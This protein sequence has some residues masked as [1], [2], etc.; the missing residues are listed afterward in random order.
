LVLR[1]AVR[2]QDGEA[3]VS[4][5]E[6]SRAKVADDPTLA[7]RMVD[8]LVKTH[9]YRIEAPHPFR[10]D[11]PDDKRSLALWSFREFGRWACY[12]SY[13]DTTAARVANPS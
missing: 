8:F 13:E 1:A 7:V 6:A 12:G 10:P 3:I 11:L 5:V 9:L 2:F 4:E